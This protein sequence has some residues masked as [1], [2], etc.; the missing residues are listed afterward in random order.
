MPSPTDHRR[1]LGW[2]DAFQSILPLLRSKWGMGDQVLLS[3]VL[4][5]GRSGALVYVVDVSTKNFEGQAI[6]K[7]EE[8]SD[9]GRQ[10]KLE[11]ALHA[12]AIT[13]SPEFAA[14]HLPRLLQSLHHEDKLAILSTIAG[15][16]LEYADPWHDLSF[17][18]QLEVIRHVSVAMLEDWNAGYSLSPGLLMPQDLLRGWLGYRIDPRNGGR[19]HGF[20]QDEC[21]IPC[22]SPSILVN[23]HW[24]PNPLAFCD[25]VVEV[26]ERLQLRGALGHT[27]NDFHG[28]N[29]LVGKPEGQST[30]EGPDYY[31]IDLA[32]YQSK[33]FLLYDH[34]YFEFTTLL[35]NRGERS[36]EDWEAAIAPLRR[37]RHD[38]D[39][40]LK[41]DD[42]GLIEIIETLRAGVSN[43]INT[44]EADRLAYMESQDLL[45]R[46]AVGLNFTHKR[47]PADM[48]RKAF[49]YAAANLKDYLKFNRIK[50]PKHGE[51]LVISKHRSAPKTP[52]AVM[53]ASG[54]GTDGAPDNAG[55][56]VPP[57]APATP[58]AATPAPASGSTGGRTGVT[59]LVIA[60]VLALAVI[61]VFG[62][63]TIAARF[64]TGMASDPAQT[65]DSAPASG[66]PPPV[67]VA[68]MPFTNA[69]QGVQDDF[70][71]GL[72]IE[73]IDVLA[74]TKQL[75]V[76]GYSS[77]SKFR[78]SLE[79]TA[80]IGRE[81][82]VDY[83]AE[84]TVSQVNDD[85]RIS[86]NL[87]AASTGDQ[88]WSG[89]FEENKDNVFQA[90]ED[91]AKAIGTALSVPLDVRSETLAANRTL[92]PDAYTAYLRGI[93]LLEQ[94]GQALV[95]SIRALERAVELEP[96][97]PAAWAAL[98]MAYNLVPTYL[99]E[100]EGSNVRPEYY[101]RLSRKAA[102]TALDQNPDL[103]DAQHAAGNMYQ[104][105][106]QWSRSEIAYKRAL[107]LDPD[108]HRAMQDYGGLLQTAG[109][110][111]EALELL[112]R[113]ISLDPIND[114]YHLMHARVSL[115]LTHADADL[116]RIQEVFRTAP[117][118]RELAFRPILARRSHEGKLDE[119]RDLIA[120][121]TTCTERFRSRA[122]SMIDAAGVRSGTEIF[123]EYR[124]EV[125]LG[126]MF[127]YTFGSLDLA[128]DAFEY[129]ALE[130]DY[131]LQYFTVPWAM[132]DIVGPDSRF[133]TILNDMGLVE[134]WKDNGWSPFCAQKGDGFVCNT[135]LEAEN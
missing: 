127:L 2:P 117:A 92:D 111:K 72:T 124:N 97:F 57:P 26:P 74:S 135:T 128:L 123:D 17:D 46:V 11:A 68:V 122:L 82:G 6:L 70:A 109:K 113:A 125:F 133:E 106:R 96:K 88:I 131:R 99:F 31:L 56:P 114:L 55:R 25:S 21:G 53:P 14:L 112:A 64:G 102:L 108:N 101:Y 42:H 19:I 116:D 37:Y 95:R 36:A 62:W 61:A 23:G 47:L 80:L 118:L 75:R 5:N 52:S 103:S 27:H 91:L 58:G 44:H 18:R 93:A 126:Y 50:W 32:M 30:T 7:L 81:L 39:V 40:E 66:E 105:I 71:D 90:Q 89:K 129:S 38:V 15:R 94:R 24:Y 73:I 49:F 134:Y 12:E 28:F 29:L 48:R 107:A 51:E 132:L 13:D 79:D 22:T 130:S 83:I 85:V 63:D 98:S 54:V 84:G 77:S 119:A 86:V 121:C 67:S 1:G 9:S 10:E 87:L 69:N 8:V 41:T 115:Q 4:G 120:S 20:I 100:V 3:R 16:A 65:E 78:G 34:A 43:W 59:G 45:A 35:A 60:A 110:P 104:R 76:P 33:T